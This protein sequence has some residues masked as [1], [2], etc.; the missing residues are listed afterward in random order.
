MECPFVET[1]PG[2]PLGPLTGSE[3]T[4]FDPVPHRH[5]RR[6][7][8]LQRGLPGVGGRGVPGV[9][10]GRR[11]GG[12]GSGR[13][14]CRVNGRCRGRGG[15]GLRCRRLG[16]AAAHQQRRHQRASCRHPSPLHHDRNARRSVGCTVPSAAGPE[17]KGGTQSGSTQGESAPC[18]RPAG[19]NRAC[20]PSDRP[21]LMDQRE[22][23]SRPCAV[24]AV[25]PRFTP[26]S[27]RGGADS[28]PVALGC[29]GPL[30]SSGRPRWR[31]CSPAGGEG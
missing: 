27:L 11:V 22:Q 1:R 25:Q 5:G 18:L 6:E 19:V 24:V 9:P 8:P 2:H 23:S 3:G 16:T 17:A 12:R 4:L 28:T 31:A 14:G 15:R 30:T 13:C 26:S 21:V 29:R 7:R 20:E 10:G